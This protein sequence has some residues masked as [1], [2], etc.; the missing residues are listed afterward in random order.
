VTTPC[1]LSRLEAA[2][3]IVLGIEPSVPVPTAA[4]G[5]PLVAL[6]RAIRPA[7]EHPP[8]LV[9]F[10]GGRDSS[11][12]L[13]LAA[14]TARRAGLPAP[15]PATLRFPGAER[16]AE[17]DWQESVVSHLGLRD[18]LRIEV[19][20]EL[21]CVGPLATAALRRD[22]LLWPPNSHFHVP[23]LERATGGSLVTGIGGDEVFG[24][25]RWARPAA[26]LAGRVRPTPRDAFRVGLA[27]A[28]ESLRRTVFRRRAPVP[29]PWLRPEARRAVHAR[30]A[31]DAA[32]EPLGWAS[33]LAWIPR[34]RAFRAG[35]ASVAALAAAA[36]VRVVH[37]LA[38]PGFHAALARIPRSMRFRPRAE[39]MSALFEDLLPGEVLA[40][41]GKARFGQ[42]AWGKH[43]RALVARWAGEGVDPELVGV[44]PELVDVDALR[45]AWAQAERDGRLLTVLQSIWLALDSAGHADQE[46]ERGR[47]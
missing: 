13:A 1:R 16:S 17:V 22:G 14:R 44:D 5:S 25:S 37:P 21:D 10:S 20:D 26:V 41:P 33:R 23:L 18:W 27:L 15:V 38:D 30:L 8:C 34:L 39:L 46:V 32:S 2:A 4:G 12:V 45:R 43:S 42:V 36:G 19:S 3:G 40:R 9:S 11:A 7:L 31:R 47:E 28:P 35:I 6:E 29:F 24:A